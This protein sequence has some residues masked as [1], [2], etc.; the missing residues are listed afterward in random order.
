M[1]VRRSLATVSLI[2]G[3]L[4]GCATRP[5]EPD[6]SEEPPAEDQPLDIAVDSL[7]IVH[8][9]L[10]LSA[11][12]VDGA[13]DLSVRLG[14]TCEHREVGGGLSTRS[15]LVWSLS[16]HDVAEAIGCG[17]LVRTHVR[18]PTRYVNKVA[19]LEVTVEMAA[20][21]DNAEDG[22][23]LQSLMTSEPGISVMFAPVTRGARLVTGDSILQAAQPESEEAPAA[24]G[25]TRQFLVPRIDFARSVLRKRPLHLDGSSFV[26]SLSVGGTSLE[27]EPSAAAPSTQDPDENAPEPPPEEGSPG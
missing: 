27:N 10:R 12:M 14:G 13:A 19:E 22:P 18:D 6:L 20:D 11:T 1:D 8:G 2:V 4:G 17:L 26:T 21:V 7:D 23:Q 24:S 3:A 25:D 5:G 16:D 15:T 9:A